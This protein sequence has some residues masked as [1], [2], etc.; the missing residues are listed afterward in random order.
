MNSTMQMTISLTTVFY[1]IDRGLRVSWSLEGRGKNMEETPPRLDSLGKRQPAED[2][3]SSSLQEALD[4]IQLPGHSPDR[5]A[6]LKVQQ[7]YYISSR[8]L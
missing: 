5:V 1:I 4:K 7:E 3:R 6:N 2:E 8:A